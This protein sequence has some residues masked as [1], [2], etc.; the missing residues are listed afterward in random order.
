MADQRRH[1]RKKPTT[2]PEQEVVEAILKGIWSVLAFFFRLIFR[3]GK[4]EGV[5][6]D[7]TEWIRQRQAIE[8]FWQ[9]VEFH[10]MQEHT[11]ALA[12]SEADKLLDAGLQL[13][14]VPG[15]TMGERLKAAESKFPRELYQQIWEAHKL[16][17]SLAHEVGAS[18][19]QAE[20]EKAVR[21]FR[22]AL[23]YIGILN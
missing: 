21:S 23:N 2:S 11:R 15:Q 13:Q 12:V 20:A 1:N 22:A 10:L 9:D 19:A 3:Q 18:V 7:G 5:R 14:K 6:P 4:P 8:E 17:N 16:R